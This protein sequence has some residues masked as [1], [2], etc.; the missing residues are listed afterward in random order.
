M[1]VSNFRIWYLIFLGDNSRLQFLSFVKSNYLL[2]FIALLYSTAAV[3]AQNSIVLRDTSGKEY[4]IKLRKTALKFVFKDSLKS[5]YLGKIKSVND[6]GIRL[7]SG[8]YFAFNELKEI[9]MRRPVSVT[10]KPLSIYYF[11]V[12]NASVYLIYLGEQVGGYGPMFAGLSVISSIP[13]TIILAPAILSKM[14][15]NHNPVI[16]NVERNFK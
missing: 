7:K 9:R 1:N 8:K 10:Y 14:V 15:R 13:F 2:L 6:K 16:F 11:V 4:E 3:I 5:D 12:V